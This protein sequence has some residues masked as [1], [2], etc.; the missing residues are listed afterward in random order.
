M[1]SLTTSSLL[2]TTKNQYFY[3]LKANI[4]SF[5]SLVGIQLL[6]MLFSFGG[7][8]S[9]GFGGGDISV[10]IKYY[11]SDMIFAFTMIWAF[12]TALTITTKPYRNYDFSFVTNRLSSS[13]ANILFLGS[14]S[15]LGGLTSV[16]SGNLLQ[17]IAMLFLDEQLYYLQGGSSHFILGISITFFYLFLIS[18]IGYL[19]GTLVQVSKL[20]V[21]II[22]GLFI[23]SLFLQAAS[24]TEPTL[25][26]IIQYYTMEPTVSLFI[27]KA[28]LT[29]LALF[30]VAISILNRL[31]VR[32]S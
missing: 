24:S 25:W 28:V 29:T 23:G 32:R 7:V 30:T 11:S 6:A 26:K 20:F 19:V 5:S 8:G 27:L 18:S 22:P 31:E 15:L 14:A 10:N 4:D 2:E 12:I 9:S 16:L 1:M 3:K 17:V 21:V 13:L